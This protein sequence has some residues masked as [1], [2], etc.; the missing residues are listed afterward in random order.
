ML[1][2]TVYA[3]DLNAASVS[4]LKE[5]KGIGEKIANLII[6]ERQRAGPFVSLED[7]SIRV[8]GIGKKRLQNLV[9]QGLRV[10]SSIE[11]GSPSFTGKTS[12]SMAPTN[13]RKVAGSGSERMA[14][15]VLIKPPK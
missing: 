3:L 10:D 11:T 15:P 1:S 2:A 4:Q 12:N 14:E 5:L 7:F 8:K 6:Q 9:G 13:R